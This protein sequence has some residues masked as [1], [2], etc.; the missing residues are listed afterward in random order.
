MGGYFGGPKRDRH[1]LLSQGSPAQSLPKPGHL[2]G[3]LAE[4]T[5]PLLSLSPPAVGAA[6]WAKMAPRPAA[7]PPQ[8]L[9][10]ASNPSASPRPPEA[11]ATFQRPSPTLC[12]WPGPWQSPYDLDPLCAGCPLPTA[13]PGS[14]PGNG[15]GSDP[16]VRPGEGTW[17]P[18]LP[19]CVLGEDIS[20]TTVSA[21][22]AWS[23]E[24]GFGSTVGGSFPFP[25]CVCPSIKHTWYPWAKLSL[26]RATPPPGSSHLFSS[27][28]SLALSRFGHLLRKESDAEKRPPVR[29]GKGCSKGRSP[30]GAP[31]AGDPLAVGAQPTGGPRCLRRVRI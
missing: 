29:L 18:N 5:V 31:T 1:P 24:D 25:V 6:A 12:S 4:F 26:L 9:R 13:G 15:T 8:P 19:P 2:S 22:G 3:F 10:S 11:P 17:G 7:P 21:M 20:V 27:G 28:L 14:R 16:H 30:V 23:G